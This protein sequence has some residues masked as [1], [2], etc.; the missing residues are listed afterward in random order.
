MRKGKEKSTRVSHHPRGPDGYLRTCLGGLW[1]LGLSFWSSP[2]LGS[3]A[4]SES[5]ASLPSRALQMLL[6]PLHNTMLSLPCNMKHVRKCKLNSIRWIVPFLLFSDFPFKVL[7]VVNIKTIPMS[8]MKLWNIVW[9]LL[10]L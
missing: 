2:L 10:W 6:K 4:A 5:L 3:N 8:L 7:C 1:Y 9:L